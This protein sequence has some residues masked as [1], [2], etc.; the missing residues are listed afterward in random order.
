MGTLFRQNDPYRWVQ[1][2]R[3]QRHTPV[4]TKSE[5]PP[6]PGGGGATDT[7]PSF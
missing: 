1:V 2:W 7:I 6:P 5:N 4:G 3:L